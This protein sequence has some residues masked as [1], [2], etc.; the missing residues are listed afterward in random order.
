MSITVE[1]RLRRAAELLDHAAVPATSAPLRDWT[2]QR[3]RRVGPPVWVRAA[4]VLLVLGAM[5]GVAW[6]SSRDSSDPSA[7]ATTARV[8]DSA[9]GT[10]S[11]GASE[12]TAAAVDSTAVAVET[13]SAGS[14]ETVPAIE[15]PQQ[16]LPESADL[17]TSP[18]TVQG[19]G[20]SSWY[21]L[22]P[23]LDVAWY[24]D[25]QGD[26]QLCFRTPALEQCQPDRF[27][28]GGFVSVRSA[29]G[30]WLVVTMDPVDRLEVALDDGTRRTV[31]VQPDSQIGWRTGRVVGRTPVDGSMTFDGTDV[32][33]TDT[34][35]ATT[36]P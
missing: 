27:V 13:T 16:S 30:H 19:S 20:P 12:T 36:Q 26:S 15:G 32:S 23:D 21:R 29:G 31:A 28:P 18:V 1:E 24:S 35:L 33:S 3:P 4:A 22:Q 10:T 8:L 34:V 6:M 11:G 2:A 9:A 7:S 14:T 5:G 17:T 25:G